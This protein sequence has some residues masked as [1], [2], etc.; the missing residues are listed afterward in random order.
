M[1]FKYLGKFEFLGMFNLL[2]SAV[3]WDLMSITK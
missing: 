2:F 3:M 1:S